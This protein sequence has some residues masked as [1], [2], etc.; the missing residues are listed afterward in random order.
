MSLPA[1]LRPRGA[2]RL[3]DIWIDC[4]EEAY[5]AV[6]HEDEYCRAQ[7]DLINTATALRLQQPWLA[8]PPQMRGGAVGCTRKEA[9]WKQDKLV[10]YRYLPLPFVQRARLQPVLI[11]YALVNRPYVLDLQ[12]E[13]SLV[14]SLLAAG[15][16]VYLIDWGYPDDT[17]RSL[18]LNDY[19]DRYLGGCVRQVLGASRAAALNLIGICQ[20]GTLSLCYSALHPRQIANLVLLATPVD[21]HTPDNL[22]WIISFR[23]PPPGCWGTTSAVATTPSVRSTRGTS[24]C[25]SAVR[26]GDASR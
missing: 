16:D 11:S 8:P 7:A 18:A 21:F 14:R 2:R 9:I 12:P 23:R 5:A 1:R 3:Y 6:A 22:L 17:D 4:A 25:M 26:Q 20:G 10:L 19:I 13:R 15:L 24:G